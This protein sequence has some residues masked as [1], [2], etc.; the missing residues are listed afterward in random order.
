MMVSSYRLCYSD[1]YRKIHNFYGD[2]Q[3][4]IVLRLTML[5]LDYFVGYNQH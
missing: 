2:S 5:T 4:K 3:N 1:I